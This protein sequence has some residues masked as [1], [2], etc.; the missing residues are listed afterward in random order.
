MW[1]SH[2]PFMQAAEAAHLGGDQ[3]RALK[4]LDACVA[5]RPRSAY[6]RLLAGKCLLLSRY[7]E[8]S[9]RK[10]SADSPDRAFLNR[11]QT[12]YASV[13][14]TGWA[15]E[16][17]LPAGTL[18]LAGLARLA[19]P[20]LR[21]GLIEEEVSPCVGDHIEARLALAQSLLDRAED[22][23]ALDGEKAALTLLVEP[24]P[25]AREAL[26]WRILKARALLQLGL[27]EQAA[28]L[29][30]DV[31]PPAA[32]FAVP[33][34]LLALRHAR[35]C[36]DPSRATASAVALAQ[37]LVELAA[38]T[39][40][41]NQVEAHARLARFW[42]RSDAWAP[43]RRHADAAKHLVETTLAL[44]GLAEVKR[45]TPSTTSSFEQRDQP[46]GCGWLG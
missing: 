3:T 18:S 42:R 45:S 7:G 21:D 44:G 24:G 25:D 16:P 33:L 10:P 30:Q 20:K 22:S 27:P 26:R 5:D 14:L 29:L 46:E 17:R 11:R 43:A 32:E 37:L 6:P 15:R 36:E 13:S 12:I 40:L 39:A 19:P 31:S 4:W 1:P 34:G 8:W 41:D 2:D 35:A 28:G 23:S 38:E 9:A